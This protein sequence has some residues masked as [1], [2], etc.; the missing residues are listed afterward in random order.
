MFLL[1][2]DFSIDA[3]LIRIGGSLCISGGVGFWLGGWGCGAKGRLLWIWWSFPC[4]PRALC[5]RTPGVL[6]LSIILE[7]AGRRDT[8]PSEELDPPP[9][10]WLNIFL[11]RGGKSL[12]A[13]R[14][15]KREKE[16]IK[17]DRSKFF[18]KLQIILYLIK[19][20]S[21]IAFNEQIPQWENC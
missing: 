6:G 21:P 8:S 7:A 13:T 4:W 5:G 10:L 17:C 9:L 1:A 14:I 15:M 12:L 16:N 2:L 19:I 20:L 18:K 3:C 11:K